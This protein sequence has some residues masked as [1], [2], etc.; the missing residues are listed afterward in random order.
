[1]EANLMNSPEFEALPPDI[2]PD[3]SSSLPEKPLAVQNEGCDSCENLLEKERLD[4]QAT[5]LQLEAALAEVE[6]LQQAV[7]LR[8]AAHEATKR[9]CA[10]QEELIAS[11]EDMQSIV[12]QEASAAQSQAQLPKGKHVRAMVL[13][14]WNTSVDGKVTHESTETQAVGLEEMKYHVVLTTP[15]VPPDANHLEVRVVIDPPNK[16]VGSRS[17]TIS[18]KAPPRSSSPRRGRDPSPLSPRGKARP[19]SPQ[20]RVNKSVLG[21]NVDLV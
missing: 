11:M 16:Q 18:S 10:E 14:E 2:P 5:K 20:R 15:D 17:A 19:R 21:S 12:M 3:T 1:M 7:E 8:N 4:H 9:R 13:T 6:K